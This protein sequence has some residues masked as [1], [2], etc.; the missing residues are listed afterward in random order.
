MAYQLVL[1]LAYVLI[2][3]L[4]LHAINFRKT[5]TAL[6]MDLGNLLKGISIGNPPINNRSQK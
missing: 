5:Q 4:L 3:L 1:V 6:T 2:P